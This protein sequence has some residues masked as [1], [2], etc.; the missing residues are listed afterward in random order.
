[1]CIMIDR[2]IQP[3][4]TIRFAWKVLGSDSTRNYWTPLARLGRFRRGEWVEALHYLYGFNCYARKADA[5]ALCGRPIRVRIRRVH[6]YGNDQGRK[7]I[8]AREIFVPKG[9]K[10]A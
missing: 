7:V 4:S 5:E 9:R 10:R 8:F 6:G 3:R 2:E 1:M